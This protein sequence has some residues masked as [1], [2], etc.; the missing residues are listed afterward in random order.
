MLK[1]VGVAGAALV[2]VF[3]TG[4]ANAQMYASFNAGA[5]DVDNATTRIENGISPGTDQVFTIIG[6]S[7]YGLYGAIGW[8]LGAVR[9]EGEIGS[10]RHDNDRYESQ[11]PGNVV[12]PLDGAIDVLTGMVNAYYDFNASG[13]TPYIGGG[14]GVA[15][16]KIE[17]IG[18]RPTA[19]TGPSVTLLNDE[20]VDVAWQLMAGVAVPVGGNISITGQYRYFEAGTVDILDVNR[21]ATHVDVK[22]D[23]WEIGARF[24]F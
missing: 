12:R 11:V 2:A 3:A 7:G 5:S 22:G 4:T 19:P 1:W 24:A 8:D 20:E 16:A 6:G 21:R 23:G 14:V 18:P 9:V 10:H 13:F 17:A 15:H